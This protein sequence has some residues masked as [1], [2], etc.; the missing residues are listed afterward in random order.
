[1]TT[2]DPVRHWARR[3]PDA[4]A[5]VTP[6]ETWSWSD[7]EAR[8]AACAA[9][10]GGLATGRLGVVARHQPDLVVLVLAALRARRTLAPVSTRWPAP[11]RAEAFD[12]L[13]VGAVAADGAAPGTLRLRDLAAPGTSLDGPPADR[14]DTH[15][16]FAI[17]HT[18][19]STG[20]PKAVLQTWGQHVASARGLAARFPLGPG[21]RWLLDLPLYHVGG[22][23]VVVRCALAGA[24]LALPDAGTGLA[25][26]ARQ[27]APTHAS[28]VSTQLVRLLREDV[29]LASLRVVLLGGSAFPPA[30][31]DAAV[32]RGLPVVVGYGMTETT[33]TVTSSSLPVDRSELATSGTALPGREVRVENGEV[34]VRGATLFEGYVEPQTVEPRTGGETLRRPL[35]PEGWFATG[36]RGT[37]DARGRLVVHGR[38]GNGFVS[39]G[40]N[41]QPEAI[42]AALVALPSV[43]DAVVVPVP[44]PEYGAR[45]VAFVRPAEGAL[46]PGALA[47]AVRAALPGFMVP[48]AFYAWDGPAGLKPDR[49]GLAREAARRVGE[50]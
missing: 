1:M 4:P 2:P 21:D 38:I 49:V 40:E 6:S 8:V 13:G 45:P 10:L 19:G 25:D 29:D 18:S 30:L 48:D 11:M 39:G 26:T 32:A 22:L 12:R 34:W 7:L 36:D 17:L 41:V 15:Y 20:A 3:Q 37:V 9:R 43:A 24:T 35:T 47:R 27:L 46:D 44:S 16:S 14:I 33:S 5:L 42:E 31:L 23:A 50:G 28:L